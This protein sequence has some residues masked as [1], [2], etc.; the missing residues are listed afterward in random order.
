MTDCHDIASVQVD[1][2]ELKEELTDQENVRS[3]RF[4]CADQDMN[5]GVP[6]LTEQCFK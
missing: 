2:E 5:E 3:K 4:D 6:V 1:E